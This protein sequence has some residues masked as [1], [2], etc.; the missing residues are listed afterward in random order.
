[1]FFKKSAEFIDQM[2][3]DLI[4]DRVCKVFLRGDGLA[5][6]LVPNEFREISSKSKL[7]SLILI[8]FLSFLVLALALGNLRI[9]DER[10]NDPF[11]NSLILVDDSR[12]IAD[13]MIDEHGLNSD[14]SFEVDTTLKYNVYDR[15]ILTKSLTDT[16]S[17]VQIRTLSIEDRLWLRILDASN[18]EAIDM[19]TKSFRAFSDTSSV[20]VTREL[21]TKLGYDKSETPSH[22]AYLEDEQYLFVLPILAVVESLP[23]KCLMAMSPLLYHK[24]FS[25]ISGYGILESD[26]TNYAEFYSTERLDEGEVKKFLL[27]YGGLRLHRFKTSTIEYSTGSTLYLNQLILTSP[28]SKLEMDSLHQTL[29]ATSSDYLARLFLLNH[30]LADQNKWPV[31]PREKIAIYFSGLNKIDEFRNLL[32]GQGIPADMSTFEAKKNFRMVSKLTYI[33]VFALLVFSLISIVFYVKGIVDTHFS[34]VQKNLGALMASGISSFDLKRYYF[35]VF[36][37]FLLSAV[38]VAFLA[39]YAMQFLFNGLLPTSYFHIIS[40]YTLAF[41]VLLVLS[42]YLFLN[43]SLSKYLLCTPG[44]ILKGS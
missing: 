38:A 10:V 25:I 22:L 32:K 24:L 26:N 7:P 20:I 3:L 4:I 19:L 23:D 16:L 9:L 31:V 1:M 44:Q 6:S 30:D 34:K 36:G 35:V 28:L 43:S 21:L 40:I 5:A 14:N 33:G 41:I 15:A 12:G 27:E 17:D 29:H 42:S 37:T 18:V 13:R 11:S 39:V 2:V 8:F